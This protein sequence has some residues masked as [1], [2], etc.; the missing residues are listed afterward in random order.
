M[1]KMGEEPTNSV[2]SVVDVLTTD[3]GFMSF[4]IVFSGQRCNIVMPAVLVYRYFQYLC[5]CQAARRRRYASCIYIIGMRQIL[6]LLML[7]LLALGS[8][9]QRKE[10]DAEAAAAA[11]DTVPMLIMQVQKCSRLYTAEYSIHKIVTYDDIVRLKGNVLKRDFNIRLP[12]G[13]RKIAIPMD[14]KLKAYIDFSGFSERNVERRGKKITVILPDPKVV[15]TSTK[16]DHANTKEFVSLTRSRFSDAEMADL[17]RQGRA[18]IIASIPNLGIIESARASAA[19]VLIP[20]VEQ[21]GYA[22]GDIT[23]TFRKDFTGRDLGTLLDNTA[24]EQ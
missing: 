17:E 18:A 12:L 16:V 20:M 3:L 8:C 13:D 21:M 22:E 6:L 7:P 9:S 14:A 24:I 4:C 5:R 23:I 19:R 11:I 10:A 15:L 2:M 1:R